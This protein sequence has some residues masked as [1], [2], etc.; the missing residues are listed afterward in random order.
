MYP[1]GLFQNQ[2]LPGEQ[3]QMQNWQHEELVIKM[4]MV[5][6][7]FEYLLEDTV[8]VLNKIHERKASNI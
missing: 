5:D 8:D 3:L 4:R 1:V 6:S 7:L 2:E